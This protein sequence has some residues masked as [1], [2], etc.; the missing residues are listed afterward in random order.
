MRIFTRAILAITLLY[1][2]KC[3]A[4]WRKTTPEPAIVARLQVQAAAASGAG[5]RD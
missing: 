2:L 1:Y 4:P 5:R 3:N